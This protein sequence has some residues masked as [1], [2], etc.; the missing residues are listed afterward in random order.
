MYA[1][2][3][4]RPANAESAKRLFETENRKTVVPLDSALGIDGIPFKMT[5]SIMLDIAYWAIKLDS[6]QETE[7][8]SSDVM[9]FK[10]VTTVSARL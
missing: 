4:L 9:T 8:F 5:I 7:D 3:V 1:R 2:Y 6:Y 10:L